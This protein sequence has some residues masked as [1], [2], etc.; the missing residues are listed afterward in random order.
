[1]SRF[2][3]VLVALALGGIVLMDLFGPSKEVHHL[4]DRKLFFAI[5]GFLGC[6]AIVLVSQAL[7]KFWLRRDPAYYE[8]YHPP[9]PGGPAGTGR[10]T[11]S[12]TDPPRE[13]PDA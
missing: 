11:G 4:W 2:W 5:Y 13:G 3:R 12:P 10:P 6:A 8:P 7:G 1:M 9:E